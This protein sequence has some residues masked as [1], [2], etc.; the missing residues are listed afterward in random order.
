MRSLCIALA[1]TTSCALS[2]RPH[3]ST[4]VSAVAPRRAIASLALLSALSTLSP[5]PAMADG[6]VLFEAKCA[7]CHAG[8]G[9]VVARGKTLD[10]AALTANN[11]DIEAIVTMGKNQMPGF[12]EACA[13]KPACTFG[14]RLSDADIAEVSKWVDARADDG[15]W[16]Q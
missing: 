14:A 9:N 11:V 1:A 4:T 5:R 15:K 16:S 8:G 6:A 13:P 7:A 10:R 3:W 12:G 2:P